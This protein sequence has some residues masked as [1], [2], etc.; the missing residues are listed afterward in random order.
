MITRTDILNMTNETVNKQR[1]D[2]YGR[3]EDSFTSIAAFWT[4]HLRAR[5]L[6]DIEDEISTSDVAVMM[7]LLKCARI[8]SGEKVHLDNWVDI[9]GYAACGGEIESRVNERKQNEEDN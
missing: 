7:V 4:A 9:A 6:M 8:A 2:C 1:Q 3:P 5:R